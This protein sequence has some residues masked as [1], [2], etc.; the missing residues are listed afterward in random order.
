[1]DVEKRHAKLFELR[2]LLVEHS[3]DI[4]VTTTFDKFSHTIQ[5]DYVHIYYDVGREQYVV[6]DSSIYDD[7]RV[8]FGYAFEVLE[9]VVGLIAERLEL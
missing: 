2:E 1:M 4:G 3:I 7:S 9:F 6:Y 8:Y 5:T